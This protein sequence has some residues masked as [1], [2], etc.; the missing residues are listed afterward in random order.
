MNSSS[1][2]VKLR[3]VVDGSGAKVA[4]L[5]SLSNSITAPIA[6]A[7]QQA[8]RDLNQLGTQL[9]TKLRQISTRAGA[10]GGATAATPAATFAQ[11]AT[12]AILGPVLARMGMAPAGTYTGL[13]G[14]TFGGFGTAGRTIPSAG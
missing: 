6:A 11:R 2:D 9:D 12:A 5:E 8:N 3:I 10:F 4:G 7:T 14:A 1:A 13:A